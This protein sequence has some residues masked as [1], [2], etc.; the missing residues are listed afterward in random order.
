MRILVMAVAGLGLAAGSLQAQMS[1]PTKTVSDGGIKL[2][3]W[4]GRVDPQAAKQGKKISDDKLVTSAA[5]AASQ[6]GSLRIIRATPCI[7][8]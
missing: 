2:A 8:R 5:K 6:A 4:T 7:A 1:D 3:G